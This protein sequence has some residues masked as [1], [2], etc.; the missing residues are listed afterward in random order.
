MDPLR[1]SN[2]TWSPSGGSHGDGSQNTPNISAWASPARQERRR[3][4]VSLTFAPNPGV[5]RPVGG[6]S[7]SSFVYSELGP[8]AF[9]SALLLP[10]PSPSSSTKF[11][12]G[13]CSLGSAPLSLSSSILSPLADPPPPYPPPPSPL[14]PLYHPSPPWHIPGGLGGGGY[15]G[16]G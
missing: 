10:P 13:T 1:S 7:D 15:G 3:R 4:S 9:S 6:G 16:G 5:L 14:G 12:T 11:R 2:D 8:A